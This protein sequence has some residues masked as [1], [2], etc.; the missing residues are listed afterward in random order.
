MPEDW[1]ALCIHVLWLFTCMGKLQW[2]IKTNSSFEGWNAE[3][4]VTDIMSTTNVH[5]L[6]IDFGNMLTL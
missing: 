4:N 6:D 3:R 5:A 1:T 2:I